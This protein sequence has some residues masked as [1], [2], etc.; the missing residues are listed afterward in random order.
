MNNIV[1]LLPLYNDWK[2][3]NLLLQKIDRQISI[4]KAKAEI[5]I[6]DDCSTQK[7]RIQKR[8][9]SSI[10]NIKILKIKENL[11][12]QKIIAIGLEFLKK[13][14]NKIIIIMD[15]DGEDNVKEINKM[16]AV[17]IKNPNYIVTSCRTKRKEVLLFQ[18]LYKIY[19]LLCSLFTFKWISFGNYSSFHSRNIKKIL[20]DNNSWLA[21]SSTVLNNCNIFRLYAERNN[22]F[23]GKSKVSFQ[24]LFQHAFRVMAVFQRK[25]FFISTCYLTLLIIFSRYINF[26]IIVVIIFFILIMNYLIFKIKKN[27][28]MKQFNNKNLYIKSVKKI[29]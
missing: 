4:K 27:V 3:C 18:V 8:N 5:I 13:Y 16:I 10:K 12:S 9:F 6:L 15:S 25:I 1:F 22:R 17:S 21:F 24:G 14:K 2:S 20:S 28:N 19:L 29:M 7:G 23:Y 11:G 26:Y